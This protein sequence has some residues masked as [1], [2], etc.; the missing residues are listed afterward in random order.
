MKDTT[1]YRTENIQRYFKDIKHPKYNPIEDRF[2][3]EMFRE[4]RK[5]REQIIN[6][7]IRLVATLAKE[8]DTNEYFMDY[9]QVGIEGL[10]AAFEKYDPNNPSKFTTY[11]AYWIRAKMSLLCRE[12]NLVQRSNQGKIGSKAVKFVEQYFAE[13]MCAPSTEQIVEH[14]AKNCNIDIQYS[15]EVFAIKVTSIDTDVDDEKLTVENSGEF[16][17]RTAT[18]NNYIDTIEEEDLQYAIGVM[19]RELTAKEKDFVMRHIY[20]GE[21]YFTI[22][23]REKLTKERVRQIV[24]GGLK[25][26]KQCEFAKK[27]FACYLK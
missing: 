11:A 14:L 4:R 16:A 3:R 8:Y 23:E 22:A 10:L 19:M 25:K 26:M 1:I 6:A 27:H 18:C 17:V 5:F 13:N 12:L 2:I 15:N 7:N 24:Q 21:S 9:N 20:N